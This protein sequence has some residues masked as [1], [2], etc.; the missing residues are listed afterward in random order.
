MSSISMKNLLLRND[1]RLGM[2]LLPV[3]A[4]SSL[5]VSATPM[6]TDS[7][8]DRQEV[9]KA[10]VTVQKEY[11]YLHYLPPG[12]AEDTNR[13]WP[14]VLFLHGAGERGDDIETIKKHGLPK[15][16]AQGK[17]FPCVVVS[18]QCPV[19]EWWNVVILD[20]LVEKIASEERIDRD[21]I[22]VTGLSMGGFGTWALAIHNPNRYAA[23]LPI[24]GGGEIQRAWAIAKIPAW[25]FHG[26]LDPTVP[27]ARSQ[28]MVDALKAAGGSPR[29]TIYPGYHH[30]SWTVTYENPEV[31]DW[32]LAQRLSARQLEA[33]AASRRPGEQVPQPLTAPTV[34]PDTK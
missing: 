30:D 21:R 23:I 29:F 12:Y 4:A 31:I 5:M 1:H 25:T 11:R 34:K 13:R 19:G 14:L 7:A 16:I 27:I 10:T 26:D 8:T 32:L 17:D 24:C 28:Q 20:A 2:L 22:Y 3:L 15:L 6:N 18:P 9:A 33:P